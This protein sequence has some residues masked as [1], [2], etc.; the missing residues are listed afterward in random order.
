MTPFAGEY[1]SR[2]EAAQ[3]GST[4]RMAETIISAEHR[5]P[6]ARQQHVLEWL[7][8]ERAKAEAEYAR[9]VAALQHILQTGQREQNELAAFLAQHYGVDPAQTWTLDVERGVVSTPDPEPAPAAG[10]DHVVPTDAPVVD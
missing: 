9:A 2:P 10:V 6:L 5:E 7:L 8:G 1:N 4:E 3:A